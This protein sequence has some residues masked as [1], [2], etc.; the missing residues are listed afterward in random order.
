MGL[1]DWIEGAWDTGKRV[2]GEAVDGVAHLTGGGLDMVGLDGAG[3]SVDAWGDRTADS[4]GVDIAEADLGQTDDP[5]QLIHGDAAAI[6]ESVGHLRRFHAAFEST[7]LGLSRLDSDHWQGE[8]AEKF[9]AKFTPH[10]KQWLTASDAC[11]KAADALNTY[12]HT[13]EWAQGQAKEC[14]EQYRTA[15]QAYDHAQSAYNH[16]V[17]TYNAQVQSYAQALVAGTA[18]GTEPVRPGPFDGDHYLTQMNLAEAKLHQARQQR[19][20][21]A[22]IAGTAIEGATATAPAEPG[23]GTR[24]LD[25]AGDLS[26]GFRLGSDSFGGGL[27]KGTADMLKFVRGLDPED[28]YNLTHPAMYLD[29]VSTT[30]AGML[31]TALHPN[32]LVSAVV[33]SGWGSDP[34]EALGKLTVNLA[35][36]T[37]T[38]G[39]SVE[40][41]IAERESV[42]LVEDAARNDAVNLAEQGA[43][44][45]ADTAADQGVQGLGENVAQLD[46]DIDR[47]EVAANRDVDLSKLNGDMVWRDTDEKLFRVDDR[48]P[49]EIIKAQGFNPHDPT[50]LDLENYAKWNDH[51]AFVGTTR[52]MAGMVDMPRNYQYEIDA[53]GGIDVN[54]TLKDQSFHAHEQEVAFPGGIKLEHIKGWRKFD[55][56]HRTYGPFEPNPY[57]K[58]PASAAPEPATPVLPDGWTR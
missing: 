50:N 47:L 58:P 20:D 23:F 54:A 41:S 11:Q 2:A 10:P 52:D 57:Y 36:G 16:Q 9:R 13:V 29:H 53:P 3:K 17:A 48:S 30:A 21:A 5:K 56:T 33:G 6:R 42:G 39:G 19:D 55:P 15:S 12:A 45:T 46:E 44:D 38:D 51:S 32:Q 40:A 26:T 4:L 25:D 43:L 24:L 14:A 27:V 35:A 18:P 1:G 8:A 31:H 49:A 34:A 22:R 37:L 28:P 7:G